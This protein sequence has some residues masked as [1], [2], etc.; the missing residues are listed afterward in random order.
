[1]TV[2][3]FQITLIHSSTWKRNSRTLSLKINSICIISINKMLISMP[4]TISTLSKKM[5][6]TQTLLSMME[7]TNQYSSWTNKMSIKMIN[8]S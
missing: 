3:L 5:T 1:M 4:M 7:T 8:I 2:P 6:C